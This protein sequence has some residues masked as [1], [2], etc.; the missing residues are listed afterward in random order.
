MGSIDNTRI[1]KKTEEAAVSIGQR[2]IEESRERKGQGEYIEGSRKQRARGTV[3]SRDQRV[4]ENRE[5]EQQT[6][7]GKRERK[8]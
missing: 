2:G 1:E 4:K 6:A 8:E 5:R 7:G 3:E